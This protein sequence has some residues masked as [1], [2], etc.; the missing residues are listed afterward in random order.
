[1]LQSGDLGKSREF[2]QIRPGLGLAEPERLGIE[3]RRLAGGE[4]GDWLPLSRQRLFG[5][6]MSVVS[7]RLGLVHEVGVIIVG[8]N[9]R[10]FPSELDK[11]LLN[12]AGNQVL[13]ALHEA[14]LVREQRDRVNELDRRLAYL[15][16]VMSLGE[17]TASIAH[18]VNQP[19]TGIITN[20]YACLRLLAA[21][22]PDI[23]G[24][25]RTAER[26]IRDGERASQVIARLR[27]LFRNRGFAV[28]PLDLSEV[29]SEVVALSSHSLQ[30]RKLAIRTMFD[31]ALPPVHGDRVQIQQVILNLVLN[32][33][34][35]M[36]EA[37]N[38]PGNIFVE[39][40]KGPP[41]FGQ[42]TVRDEGCGVIGGDVGRIFEPF[43]TTKADGIGIGLSVSQSI[44][45]RH[46]G[47]IWVD[48]KKSS[49][50]AFSFC[51]PFASA[52]DSATEDIAACS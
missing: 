46:N 52:S 27:S 11:L 36:E 29:A 9:W 30:R 4:T 12:V 23:D 13:L 28:E 21:E 25:T 37:N 35:A 33:A 7:V 38:C 20:A 51:L 18:E 3:L 15:A 32:A 6:D 16:R 44:I 2:V 34:D 45:E 41:G 50:S 8:S 22:P 43:Y 39:T 47:K 48:T 5:V 14:Q 19:L 49:G 40:A 42:L 24:A 26:T 17:L 1:M 10:G 31:T